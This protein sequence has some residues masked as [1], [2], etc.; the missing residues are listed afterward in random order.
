MVEI[1]LRNIL[2]DSA[3]LRRTGSATCRL[4]S[5]SSSS[6]PKPHLERFSSQRLKSV[7]VKMVSQRQR[8][9][10]RRP[11]VRYGN[12][13]RTTVMR[14]AAVVALR[15]GASSSSVSEQ[16][17]AAL[18]AASQSSHERSEVMRRSTK[19]RKAYGASVGQGR[20][21]GKFRRH[22]TNLRPTTTPTVPTNPP[23]LSLLLNMH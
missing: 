19:L 1:S 13:G 10:R 3:P 23:S 14:C 4:P 22:T 16:S 12:G 21:F 5:W 7:N 11:W 2:F 9:R 20:Y 15:L 18:Y 8:R 6:Q 17:F